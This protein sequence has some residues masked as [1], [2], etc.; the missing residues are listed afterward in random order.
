VKRTGP[1]DFRGWRG[2]SSEVAQF[3]PPGEGLCLMIRGEFRH[4]RGVVG[5]RPH[6][7]FAFA[8]MVR[9]PFGALVDGFNW[10]T[11]GLSAILRAAMFFLANMGAGHHRAL[12]RGRIGALCDLCNEYLW[13]NYGACAEHAA[14]V[15]DSVLRC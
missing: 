7:G 1:E 6:L 13:R 12:R 2:R 11:A 10:K 3:Q 9:N 15:A 8:S 4:I 5:P 14:G